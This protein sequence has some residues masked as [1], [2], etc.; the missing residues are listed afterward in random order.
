MESKCKICGREFNNIH[1]LLLH[2][3]H[4]HKLDKKR[5]Y[6]MFLKKKMKVYVQYAVKKHHFIVYAG[7][8]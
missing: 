3:R 1:G 6:D 4:S 8:I 7:V 2:L 5:Y